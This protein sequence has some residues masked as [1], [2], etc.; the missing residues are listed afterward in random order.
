ME[1]P[2]PKLPTKRVTPRAEVIALLTKARNEIDAQIAE[3]QAEQP[4][5]PE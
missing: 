5:K 2:T 3:L 4:A 1:K